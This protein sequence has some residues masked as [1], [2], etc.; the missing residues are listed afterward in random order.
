M[1][2]VEQNKLGILLADDEENL[3]NIIAFNL[4]QEGY[5]VYAAKNG[6]EALDIFNQKR[7]VLH[8][9]LLDVSMPQMNGF[10][11]CEKIKSVDKNFPVFFLTVRNERNDRIHGLRIGADDY[12][13]KPFDLEELM[14]RIKRILSRYDIDNKIVINQREVNFDTLTVKLPDNTIH[15]LS[16]KEMSLLRYLIQHKN[17]P[18]SR[19][20]IIEALWKEKSDEASYRTIDNFIVLYRKLFEE[21]NKNPQHFLSVRGIGYIYKSNK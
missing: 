7:N 5:E 10:E 16:V 19:Q 14:L 21:D 9:A 3:R 17:K 2:L 18:V 13:N 20:E 4:Q 1:S 6:K 12:L 11:L 15:Q 8:L